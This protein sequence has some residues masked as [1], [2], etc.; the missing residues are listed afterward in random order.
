MTQSF[1]LTDLQRHFQERIPK[2]QLK[3]RTT[4]SAVCLTLICQHKGVYAELTQ[5]K[6]VQFLG[7]KTRNTHSTSRHIWGV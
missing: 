4:D 5:H 2:K 3:T 1:T 7:I 6:D